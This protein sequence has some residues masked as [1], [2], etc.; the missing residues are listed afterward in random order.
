MPEDR[1][2]VDRGTVGVRNSTNTSTR[3]SGPAINNDVNKAQQEQLA[4]IEQ[5]RSELMEVRAAGQAQ[6]TRLREMT[7]R[8]N[9]MIIAAEAAATARTLGRG[10]RNSN[11]DVLAQMDPSSISPVK[12]TTSPRRSL[13][14][15]LVQ[16][17]VDSSL[18]AIKDKLD[19]SLKNRGDLRDTMSELAQTAVEAHVAKLEKA[20]APPP[21][22]APSTALCG[23]EGQG[24]GEAGQGGF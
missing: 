4:L 12:I 6:E 11:T 20:E 10:G 22:R 23:G 13:A 5:L 21:R 9:K 15:G 2:P 3:S 7:E 24:R 18:S 16:D 19:A 8:Q 1:P 17:A 14:E